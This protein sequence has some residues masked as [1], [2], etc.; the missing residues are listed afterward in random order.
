MK[1]D[2]KN[3]KF[4]QIGIKYLNQLFKFIKIKK[5]KKQRK[6]T[7]NNNNSNNNNIE[8]NKSIISNKSKKKEEDLLAEF[9]EESSEENE[10]LYTE[11]LNIIREEEEIED[12]EE[13]ENE[14]PE[15]LLNDV[16]EDLLNLVDNEEEDEDD[17]DSN[18]LLNNLEN[19]I[20]ANNLNLQII[21]NE[22][23]NEEEEENNNNLMNGERIFGIHNVNMM[24]LDDNYN[25]EN[26]LFYEYNTEVMP[27]NLNKQRLKAEE[28][29]FYEDFII[30][31]FLLFRT[32][33]KNEL[34]YF[35]RAKINVDIF[36][37]LGNFPLKICLC[38][39]ISFMPVKGK[40]PLIITYKTTPQDHISVMYGSYGSS[41][42]ISGAINAGVPH[43]SISSCPF[44]IS[45]LTPKS[46]SFILL[47][48]FNKILSGLISRWTIP[49]L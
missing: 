48:K 5:Q 29:Q 17:V 13:E 47:F 10:G 39:C 23:E 6:E 44:F 34:I 49:L 43:E 9:L 38:N 27:T 19:P 32:N 41:S 12:E 45:L 21:Q 25:E 26:I 2:V 14:E 16:E 42:S 8:D 11:E 40:K 15:N 35:N 24:N 30:F 46:H 33:S 28:F 31:P 22:E 37:N 20:E 18:E 4:H 1:L 36:C 3:E 7:I